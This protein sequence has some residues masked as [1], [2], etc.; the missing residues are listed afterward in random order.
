MYH[1]AE[2]ALRGFYINIPVLEKNII[3]TYKRVQNME[4]IP[5]KNNIKPRIFNFLLHR[6]QGIA[7]EMPVIVVEICPEFASG[8][9]RNH[10]VFEVWKL[11]SK[12]FQEFAGMFYMLYNIEQGNSLYLF[13]CIVRKVSGFGI[14]INGAS[15]LCRR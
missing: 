1:A 13:P 6:L 15:G 5:A 2:Q 3:H 12:P 7:P 14:I 11:F 9:N 10:Q 8:R 4:K